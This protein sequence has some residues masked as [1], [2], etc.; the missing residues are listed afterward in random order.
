MEYII[1]ELKSAIDSVENIHDRGDVVAM[2]NAFSMKEK[3]ENT[4]EFWFKFI[5]VWALREP[6]LISAFCEGNYE[7]ESVIGLKV[8]YK[9]IPK[10][11]IR[12]FKPEVLIT[13]DKKKV[14]NLAYSLFD[15]FKNNKEPTLAD[16]KK[17][18]KVASSIAGMGTYSKEHLFRSSCLIT[19][20]KHPSTEF[21][22]MGGGASKAKYEILKKAG[23][24]NLRDVNYNLGTSLDAGELGY[25]MCMAHLFQ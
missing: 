25:Y 18:T 2:K 13:W 10:L 16:Y 14:I 4:P 12:Y 17:T 5:Y 1:G 22:V 3:V 21:V 20:K 15:C 24:M 11:S 9:Y 8:K 6:S 23:M 7:I 19:N